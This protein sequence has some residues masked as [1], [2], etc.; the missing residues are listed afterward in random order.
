M[1]DVLQLWWMLWCCW[2]LVVGG[3]IFKK[4]G[5]G[6]F[7]AR[8]SGGAAAGSVICSSWWL[9]WM[10]GLGW[11]ACFDGGLLNGGEWTT[12]VGTN[13]WNNQWMETTG[14]GLLYTGERLGD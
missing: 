7:S 6:C 14:Q 11:M 5:E 2:W 12:S 3:L 1:V 10:D 13:R 4:W 9:W 8:S